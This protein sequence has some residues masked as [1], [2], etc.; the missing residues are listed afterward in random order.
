MKKLH[1]THET[2]TV[3]NIHTKRNQFSEYDV[4]SSLKHI[5]YNYHHIDFTR[6]MTSSYTIT[7]RSMHL[8]IR[9]CLR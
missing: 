9:L 6:L 5:Y 7:Q 1:N 3:P 2:V 4:V 8:W